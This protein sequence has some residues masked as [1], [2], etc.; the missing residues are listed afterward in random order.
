MAGEPFPEREPVELPQLAEL[1]A[2]A[3]VSETDAQ[4]LLDNWKA[5][6]PDPEARDILEAEEIDTNVR[7]EPEP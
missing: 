6:P 1:M 7:P 4:Q 3:E 2:I 5:N